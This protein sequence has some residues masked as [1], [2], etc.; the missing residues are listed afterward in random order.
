MECMGG[1]GSGTAYI[2]F[3]DVRVPV[4]NLLGKENEG[5]KYIM[6]NLCA[7]AVSGV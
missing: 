2:T 7:L 6:D 4:E 3:E 1:W 5:F